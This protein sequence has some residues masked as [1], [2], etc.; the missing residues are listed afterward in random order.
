MIATPVAIEQIF[1]SQ[2]TLWLKLLYKKDIFRELRHQLRIEKF[3]RCIKA[4]FFQICWI[5]VEFEKKFRQNKVLEHLDK[6]KN[7]G[8]ILSETFEQHN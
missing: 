2:I 7:F 4:I 5:K 3:I 6:F 8:V 1:L